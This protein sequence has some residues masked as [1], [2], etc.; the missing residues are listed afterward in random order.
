VSLL[1]RWISVV[2]VGSL[3]FAL[4]SSVAWWLGYA[5]RVFEPAANVLALLAALSGIPAE[6]WASARE[7]RGRALDAVGR[8][9]ERNRDL[10]GDRRF[11]PLG[12]AYR[13]VFPRLMSAAVDTAVISG[14]FGRAS[15]DELVFRL[16]E[17][18]NLVHELNHRLDLTEMRM[19]AVQDVDA[20]E[21]R[22]MDE[23]LAGFLANVRSR[24]EELAGT[25]G[26]ES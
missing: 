25:L 7:R 13:R 10:L 4:L 11:P 23:A 5:P 2:T 20:K 16:Q 24:R 14:A 15:D 19:F 3:V 18:R 17:W 26:A 1:R 12:G 6:R 9:L 8:E 21:L 22:D